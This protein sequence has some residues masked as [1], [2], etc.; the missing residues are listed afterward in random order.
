MNATEPINPTS[1][2]TLR[3]PQSAPAELAGA[4]SVRRC[5]FC[6]SR[7]GTNTPSAVTAM[8]INAR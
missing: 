8:T 5:T 4:T 2:V 3:D 1:F 6:H 7:S